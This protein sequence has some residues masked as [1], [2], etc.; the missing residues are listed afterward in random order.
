MLSPRRADSDGLPTREET[1]TGGCWFL[2]LG[3]YRDCYGLLTQI[4]F[5]NWFN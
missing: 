3:V 1:A 4:V 2:E 5:C